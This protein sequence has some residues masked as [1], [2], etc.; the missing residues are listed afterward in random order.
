[1]RNIV[2]S[3]G[4]WFVFFIIVLFPAETVFASHQVDPIEAALSDDA[5]KEVASRLNPDLPETDKA[6]ADFLLAVYRHDAHA[7]HEA[8][9]LYDR[10][11]TPESHAFL[12]SLSMLE[13]RDWEGG[14][15]SVLKRKRLVDEGIEQLDRAVNAHPENP[16]VRI[17]RGIAYLRVPPYFG[18]FDEGFADMKKVIEWMEEGKIDVPKEERFFRDRSSLYYYAGQYYLKAGDP[19][20]AK[21]MFSKS[22][23]ADFHSPFAVASRK[24]IA[25]LS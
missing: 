15:F 12:G 18:K 16:Q 22:S 9:A 14:F 20:N 19:N 13:A 23:D 7:R 1:M 8:E 5:G 6:Y 2:S 4:F 21:K 24:R 3:A 11:N 17:V 10:M 25:A